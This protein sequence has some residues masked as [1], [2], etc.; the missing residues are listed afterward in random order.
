MARGGRGRGGRDNRGNRGGQHARPGRGGRQRGRGGELPTAAPGA[1]SAPRGAS[2]GSGNITVP[3]PRL[4]SERARGGP[5]DRPRSDRRARV[6]AAMHDFRYVGRRSTLDRADDS[7]QRR[8]GASPL[9]RD[10]AVGPAHPNRAPR[11]TCAPSVTPRP[12]RHTCAPSVT[13]APHPSHLRPIRHSCAGRNPRAPR[14]LRSPAARTCLG[15]PSNQ[16]D[17]N[18]RR[19]SPGFLPAQE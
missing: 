8:P 9:G 17:A 7:S 11:H 19:W 12:I 1:A 10:A 2:F 14:H 18:Y 16:R 15:G 6:A 4:P 13:P 3:Q 5:R